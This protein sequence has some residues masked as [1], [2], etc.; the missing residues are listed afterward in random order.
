MGGR[1]QPGSWAS[2]VFSPGRV[3][4]AEV[5]RR[6]GERPAL[7]A[8][9]SFASEASPREALGRLRKRLAGCRCT[10]LLAPDEYRL[11]QTESPGVPQEELR[12]ALRWRIKEM[13]DFPVEQAGIDVLEIPA[14][15]ANAG[16]SPQVFVVAASHAVLA[17]RIHAFQDAKVALA[18]IDIPELAQR[19]VAALL[20]DEN[21]GLAL[22]A[23][24]EAGGRLTF[25]CHGE[26]CASRRIEVGREALAKA[27][28]SA[29]GLH[30]RVLLDVQRSLDNFDR[31]FSFVSLSRLVV[32]AVPGA[33]GFI[34][35]LKANLYQPVEVMDLSQ[36][37]DLE[38]VPALAEPARQADA[39]LALGAALREEA[40]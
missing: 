26:L 13:V 15:Q 27:D 38:G 31:N 6:T 14:P 29:G 9:E 23:F 17:P 35:Y 10:T 19:N 12:N 18:A 16:R 2:V 33:E 11:L 24:D 7:R 5:R 30:E 25:T 4:I 3:D 32:A 28:G 22:L 39:L 40:P 34:D 37:V 21:R 36:A 1:I 8:W 20:E